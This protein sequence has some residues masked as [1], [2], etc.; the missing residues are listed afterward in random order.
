MN[1]S[2]L[3][4]LPKLNQVIFIL[5]LFGILVGTIGTQISSDLSLILFFDN[6]HWTSGT[7]FAA[8]LAYLGMKEA[9]N[10]RESLWFFIG[11]AGYAIGQIIWDIQTMLSYS[12]FPSP[13]DLFYLLLGPSLS[14]AIFH[15]MYSQNKKFNKNAYW[16][17]L[18]A[19]GVTILI[20]VLISYLPRQGELDILS[21]VVLVAYPVTLIIPILMLFLFILVLRLKLD[22]QLILFLITLSI[23]AYSW[24]NWNSMALDGKTI[25]GSWHN[26]LFSISILISGLVVSKW[27]LSYSMNS[28]YERYSESFLM[29]LPIVT[30]ILSSVAII[31]V[32]SKPI[33]ILGASPFA[34]R[35]TF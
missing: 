4:N 35:K 13:S 31:I 29:F 17:D 25:S 1:I 6:L 32:A 8:I 14:F 24:M 23:T 10:K 7:F 26:V 27:H 21:I 18:L 12:G 19:L 15:E 2:F 33:T 9:A 16:L 22:T 20:L 5:G 3:N 34:K 11:F 28:N 30:V